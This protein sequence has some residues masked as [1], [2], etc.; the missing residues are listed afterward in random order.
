MGVQFFIFMAGMHIVKRYKKKEFVGQDQFDK[1]IEASNEKQTISPGG[2][3]GYIGITRTYI[4]QLIDKCMLESYIWK[5]EESSRNRYIAISI[6]SIKEYAKKY[7]K[8]KGK[9]RQE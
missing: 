2:A 8:K 1:W 3:V 5:Q 9:S 7:Q 6:E 4:Y